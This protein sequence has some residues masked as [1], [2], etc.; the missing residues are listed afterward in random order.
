MRGETLRLDF[1]YL[2]EDPD[3]HGNERYYVRMKGK[4][5]IRLHA[6]FGTEAFIAEYW[7]ARKL[8]P[9]EAAL[10]RR[11]R[12]GTLRYLIDRYME[13]ADYNTLA[14]D[15]T[16]LLRARI[17]AKLI[18]AAGDKAPTLSPTSI[19]KGLKRRGYG[20]AKDFLTTLR[21]LYK[22]ALE[23]GLVPSDPTQGIHL[24]RRQ[25]D[26]FHSWTV[27]SYVTA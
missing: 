13:S 5:K 10:L 22:W 6:K 21:G 25:T 11:A 14:K 26:G 27:A 9:K 16:Q 18:I 23:E 15:S 3:R 8:E 20:A 12:P 4:P 19:R 24:K 17:L 7:A 2:V 1:P